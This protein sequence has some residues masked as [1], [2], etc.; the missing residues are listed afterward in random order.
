MSVRPLVGMLL[1]AM[2]ATGSGACLSVEADAPD[3]EVTQ[4]NVAFAGVPMAGRTGDVSTQ[5]TFEQARPVNLPKGFESNVQAVKVDLV[6]KSG[7]TNFDFLKLLR[8]TMAEKGSAA[9]PVEIVNYEKG[10]GTTVGATLTIDSKNPVNILDQ[11]KASS[12]IFDVVVAGAL[13]D[14]AWA[15]DMSVHFAGKVTYKY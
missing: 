15:I 1:G 8:V 13:P 5:L 11:W 2:L 7:I 14:Q 10:D 3:V 12:A 9:Q 6:A 4:H